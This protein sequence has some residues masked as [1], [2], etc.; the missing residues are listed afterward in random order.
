MVVARHHYAVEAEVP[1]GGILVAD[2]RDWSI[3]VR[4]VDGNKTD[5]FARRI[6]G[7]EGSGELHVGARPPRHIVGVVVQRLQAGI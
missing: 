3:T 7:K 1:D 6:R 5:A 4:G 2:S